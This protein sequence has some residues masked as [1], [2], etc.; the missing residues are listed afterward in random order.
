MKVALQLPANP[1]SFKRCY[2]SIK[3]NIIDTLNP[4]IFIHTWDLQG[5]DRPDVTTDGTCEEYIELYKP[6]GFE[7]E[8]LHYSYEPLQTMVPHFTSRYKCNELRKKFQ[9]QNNIKYDVV[10]MG[11]PDIRLINPPI[12]NKYSQVLGSEF[13]ME[14]AEMVT[15]D[16]F[17][18]HHFKG[19]AQPSTKNGVPADY[20]FYTSPKWMDIAADCYFELDK[21]DH[22]QPGSERLLWYKLEKEGFKYEWFKFYGNSIHNEEHVEKSYRLF[23]IEC[24]R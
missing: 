10:I 23:D 20:F 22:Y 2:D 15:E 17:W 18:I 1:R 13:K 19:P 24:V 8:K 12:S 6:N 7:I 3:K 11:R 16:S 5:S 4:D 9:Q 14:Y 21:L